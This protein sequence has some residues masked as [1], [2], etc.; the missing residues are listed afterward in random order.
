MHPGKE[1]IN[2][3]WSGTYESILGESKELKSRTRTTINGHNF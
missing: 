3:V 2:F 1:R